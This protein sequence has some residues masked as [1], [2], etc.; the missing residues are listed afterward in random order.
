MEAR[1]QVRYTD[2]SYQHHTV[3]RGS[4]VYGGVEAG[5]RDP[6]AEGTLRAYARG[7][8][9]AH[10]DDFSANLTLRACAVQEEH[11]GEFRETLFVSPA[12]DATAANG[13]E[14]PNFSAP[15]CGADGRAPL[16]P[17]LDK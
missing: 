1:A 13:K 9:G 14:P 6:D 15:Y 16:D 7:H 10:E 4:V 8:V 2:F 3:E 12:L 5:W 17:D 11:G